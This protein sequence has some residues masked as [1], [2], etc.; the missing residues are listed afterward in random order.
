MSILNIN[1]IS[2]KAETYILY[3][4]QKIRGP[5]FFKTEQEQGC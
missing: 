4:L 5:Y 2:Q 3:Q 1:V